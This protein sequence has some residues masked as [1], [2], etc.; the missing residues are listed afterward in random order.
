MNEPSDDT[1]LRREKLTLEIQALRRPFRS[2]PAVWI[3]CAT[4]IGALLFGMFSLR[5]S[6]NEWVLSQIEK[7]KAERETK[8]LKSQ[9][10]AL[11]SDNQRLTGEKQRLSADVEAM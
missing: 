1:D 11:A 3:S 2:N 5:Y 8:E 9:K 6:R 10:Q 7:N 4:A